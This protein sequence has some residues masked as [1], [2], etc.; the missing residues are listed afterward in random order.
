[1]S[2]LLFLM[3]LI[4]NIFAAIGMYKR[5]NYQIAMFNSFAAGACFMGIINLL[6]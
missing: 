3:F 5:K 4:A 6:A 1:M 2:T